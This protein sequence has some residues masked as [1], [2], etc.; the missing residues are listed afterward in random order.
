M[1]SLTRLQLP[2][3]WDPVL[4]GHFHY[5]EMF[6]QYASNGDLPTYSFIEPSLRSGLMTSIHHVTSGLASNFIHDVY[7]AVRTGNAWEQTLLVISYDEHGGCY[8]HVP[9]PRN[10]TPPDP[11]SD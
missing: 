2:Q 6:K 8:D 5:F 3:L 11:E 9:P 7:Q 4:D 10:A 1:P